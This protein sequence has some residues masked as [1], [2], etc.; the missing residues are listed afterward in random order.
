MHGLFGSPSGATV[1]T[2]VVES[3]TLRR[4][5]LLRSP[6]GG[7]GDVLQPPLRVME[8]RRTRLPGDPRTSVDGPTEDLSEAPAGPEL[9][10][11]RV[12][13]LDS[14]RRPPGPVLLAT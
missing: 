9:L 6:E 2:G 3:G 14:S 8:I 5:M 7:P 4:G 12:T 13:G 1:I 11:I 10:G